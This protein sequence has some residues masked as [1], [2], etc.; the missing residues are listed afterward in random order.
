MRRSKTY[1]SEGAAGEGADLA[2]ALALLVLALLPLVVLLLLAAAVAV[3]A[4]A[5]LLPHQ[6]LL[7]V[8]G[9]VPPPTVDLAAL[10]VVVVGVGLHP[11]ATMPVPVPV[12]VAVPVAVLPAGG[13]VALVHGAG[14]VL[15]HC[16]SVSLLQL[17]TSLIR[18]WCKGSSLLCLL[19]MWGWIWVLFIVWRVTVTGEDGRLGLIHNDLLMIAALLIIDSYLFWYYLYI[20]YFNI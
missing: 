13:L 8:H 9:V 18:W 11:H 10:A 5:A 20:L 19:N 1:E 3:A 15:R 6:V 2:D 17:A 14:V 4:M 7:R 16:W 12:T